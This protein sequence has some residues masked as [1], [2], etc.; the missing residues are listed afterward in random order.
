[1]RGIRLHIYGG[2]EVKWEEIERRDREGSSDWSGETRCT[3]EA[4]ETYLNNEMVLFGKETLLII[5]EENK[6][7]EENLKIEI[8][9][10]ETSGQKGDNP[11][12]PAGSYTFPFRYQLPYSL[13]PSFEGSVGRIRYWIT[14]TIDKPWKFD[15]R[16][17]KVFTVAGQLDLNQRPE[18][19]KV[20][21]GEDE[22]Y[23]CCL[24]CES[25]PISCNFELDRSG[26][27]PGESIP[28]KA[29]ITNHSNRTIRGSSAVLYSMVT[30]YATT[31]SKTEEN[32]IGKLSHRRILPGD[33]DTWNGDLLPIPPLPPSDQRGCRIIG[34]EYYVKFS[35][36]PTGPASQLDIR[37]K[38]IIG[39]IPLLPGIGEPIPPSY[40]PGQW[41]LHQG[42][43]QA[44]APPTTS[45][46]TP[47]YAESTF[48]K[49][50]IRDVDDTE[51]TKGDTDYAPMYAYYNE[52]SRAEPSAPPQYLDASTSPVTTLKPPVTH[53]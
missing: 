31:K 50:N 51:Y 5:L 27:V 23:I 4:N 44:F 32:I 52:G 16:T 11:T 24:C 1:M 3:H 14:G 36:V 53:Q 45:Q 2:A 17:K 9:N 38:I 13:P 8:E 7:K 20:L 49:V 48:G 25:G 42:R 39:T 41:Q 12:L 33:S 10:L 30:Y 15:D 47:T 22:I 43:V 37:L 28:I 19:M 26:Y 40:G 35:V 6:K 29:K 34:I 46:P 18:A 21:R